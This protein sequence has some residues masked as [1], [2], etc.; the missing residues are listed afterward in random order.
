M[1]HDYLLFLLHNCEKE[2]TSSPFCDESMEAT[3]LYTEEE[4]IEIDDKKQITVEIPANKSQSKSRKRK[5]ISDDE[6]GIESNASESCS[7]SFKVIDEDEAF[8]W[9]LLPTMK[10]LNRDDNF[11]FRIEIMQ[12]LQKYKMHSKMQELQSSLNN[13]INS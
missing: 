12:I 7:S 9:S 4:D 2:E 6:N 1:Y 13:T 5:A 10:T 11:Q 3:E 8:L